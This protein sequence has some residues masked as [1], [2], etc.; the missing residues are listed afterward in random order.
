MSDPSASTGLPL[1][2]LATNAVGIPTMPSSTVK[3][4]FLSSSTRYRCVST[5]WNPSSPKLKI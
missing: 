5:S 4:F 3:P 2:Q 1:P